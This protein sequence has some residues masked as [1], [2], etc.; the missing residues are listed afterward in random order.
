[1]W[2]ARGGLPPPSP[3]CWQ[4]C[5]PP[6]APMAKAS[7]GD[8][9]GRRRSTPRAAKSHTARKAANVKGKGQRRQGSD[10]K[11][12]AAAGSRVA[13]E[14]RIRKGPRKRSSPPDAGAGE[15][16]KPPFRKRR[17]K[18]ITSLYSDL[19][20]PG[21]TRKAPEIVE[22]LLALKDGQLAEFCCSQ[23]GSR[24]LQACLKWGSKEQ[25]RKIH[26]GLCESFCPR[27]CLDRFGSVVVLKVLRYAIRVSTGRSPTEEEKKTQAQ[28][29]REFLARFSGK[30]LYTTFYNRVGCRVING[31]YFSEILSEKDRRRLL[32]EIAVPP[33]VA[34]TQPELPGNRPLRQLLQ[35]DG[36]LPT[37]QRAS[38]LSHLR[39]AAEKAVDK[40]LLC[41]DVVHFLLRAFCEVASEDQLRDLA[42]KCMPGAP[43]LLSSKPGAEA[44]L[45]LLGV[46]SAKQRKVFC[47]E[48]KGKFTALATNPVDYV[49][50][51]RLAATVDDTV[52]LA[53]TM[54]AE[55]S[56]DLDTLLSDK[57]GKKVWLWLLHPGDP[58][59]FDPYV[60]KCASLPAPSALKIP[61]A[62]QQELA[63][64][65]RPMLRA[66]LLA[67]PMRA[68]ADP[69]AKD[70]LT[71]YLEAD[72]DSEIVEALAAA[73]E[74][75][76]GQ[77][78]LGRLGEG[79]ATAA[80]LAVLRVEPADAEVSLREALWRRCLQPRLPEAAVSR[81]CFLLLEL[82]QERH[83]GGSRQ[84]VAAA[85]RAER[86]TIEAAIEAAARAGGEVKGA[87]NLLAAACDGAGRPKKDAARKGSAKRTKRP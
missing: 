85:V 65:A 86:G 50:L 14:A 52:M 45:R 63:R 53:K 43:Y 81:C 3:G 28:N 38:M 69:H 49:V 67:G 80:L 20:N 72:W 87:K 16:K 24:V 8:R 46:A 29:L 71:A 30:G 27:L 41:F 17:R 64:A 11:R 54:L 59:H 4:P 33:A 21:R 32:H 48:L 74:R 23:T 25:R 36:G 83:Q 47:R 31:I 44:L 51:I 26:Q 58:R 1:M 2:G 73:A 56:A 22:D 77:Q 57:Y 42:E 7:G 34:L 68:V 15:G 82:L 12:K 70:L 9:Q 61:E 76:A 6:S 37:E 75:E 60:R 10:A 5:G 66:A 40:E 78:G 39:E 13:G 79:A 18:E 35:A 84:A 62:R 19:I 55:L